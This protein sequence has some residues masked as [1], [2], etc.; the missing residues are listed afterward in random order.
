MPLYDFECSE[1]LNT[2]EEFYTIAN[3]DIPL[4]E[5]CPKCYKVGYIIRIVGGPRP[6]DPTMLETTKGLLKPTRAF[7]ERLRAVRDAHAGSTIEVRD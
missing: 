6:I 7:N 2:F 1:C 3:M 5:S 4:E